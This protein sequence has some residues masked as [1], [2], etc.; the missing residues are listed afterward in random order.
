MG[1]HLIKICGIKNPN[2]ATDAAKAGANYIGIVF[3]P[4]SPRH[5]ELEDA[6]KISDAIYSGGAIPIAVFVNQSDIEMQSICEA[7]NIKTVQLHGNIARKNHR[8]LP[9][10][11]QRF[12]VLSE[13]QKPADNLQHLNPYRDFILIDHARPGQGN[14]INWKKFRYSFPFRWFLAG[15]LTAIN[16]Q[17]AITIL[18]P[19]GVDVSSGV[20]SSP[21]NKDIALIK[22]F[23]LAVGGH[24]AT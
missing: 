8:S 20:E 23:I 6:I 10:D 24:Y 18:Q 16:V 3:H 12:Y 7:T 2:V 15:G 22:N 5:V 4:A 21:G 13:C 19:D 14:S 17:T 11:Y 1:N 9:E